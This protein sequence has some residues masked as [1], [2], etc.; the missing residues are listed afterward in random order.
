M[1]ETK[2]TSSVFNQ[3]RMIALKSIETNTAVFTPPL[4]QPVRASAELKSASWRSTSTPLLITL[5]P[6]EQAH[7]VSLIAIRGLP[8]EMSMTRGKRGKSNIWMLTA[9]ELSG[10]AIDHPRRP[11]Q[12]VTLSIAIFVQGAVRQELSVVLPSRKNAT[13]SIS[14]E[15]KP[16]RIGQLI[17]TSAMTKVPATPHMSLRAK[18][19]AS[20]REPDWRTAIWSGVTERGP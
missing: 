3:S 19:P 4:S 13:E 18:A 16:A 10:L 20:Q 14:T 7:L 15:S 11:S 6:S 8:P 1:A 5:A 17:K 12:P 2:L 9:D